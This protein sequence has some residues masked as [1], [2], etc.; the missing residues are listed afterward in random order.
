MKH[1]SL[2]I[3]SFSILFTLLVACGTARV[4]GVPGENSS[5]QHQIVILGTNDIHGALA[6]MDLKTR[7]E[8]GVKPVDYQAG[9][10]VYLASYIHKLKSEFGDRLLWL[11][12]GD[13]FQGTIE[14]NTA[15]G[16]PMVQ[17]FNSLGLD[18]AAIGNHEFDYGADSPNNPDLLSSLEDRMR[19]AKYPYLAA[20][21]DDKNTGALHAFP[22]T[23][24]SKIFLR[25]GVKIGVIGLSTLDTPTTTRAENVKSL[26]FVSL[27]DSTIREAKSLRDQGAQVIL[28]TAHVGI[29][30]QSGHAASGH[31][32]RKPTDD[33]GECEPGDEMTRLLNSLPA[34]TVDAVVSGHSHTVVH[35]WVNGIP[36]IQAGASGRYLNLIYLT[37]DEKSKTVLPALTRIEGPIPVCAKVFENQGDCNGDRPDPKKGRGPLVPA[38]FH[39]ETISADPA[40]VALLAPV[41]AKSQAIKAEVLGQALTPIEHFRTKESPLGNFVADAARAA[42]GADFAIVNAGGIRANWEQGP[43]TYGAVFRSLPFDNA[44]VKIDVT[45]RQLKMVLRVAESGSRGF[46]PVSGMT[47]K[48]IDPTV[49]APVN[50]L[51]GNHKI[52]PWEVNR[53]LEVK[54]PNGKLVSDDK[55]YTL[56]T[57]DFLAT[58]GDDYSW[59]MSQIP[60]DRFYFENALLI[61]D[62]VAS[63]LKKSGPLG[64]PA[65]PLVDANHPRIKF[66]KLEKKGKRRRS[67]HS[68]KRRAKLD[69]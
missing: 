57:I 48:L 50:D 42:T 36:V 25:N 6:P 3:W 64:D 2:S 8:S 65:H 41:F 26:E 29:A 51:N 22:N 49:E 4:E 33:Q 59:P 23:L 32:F 58:G 44:L 45:G 52:E 17:L 1:T 35:N 60:K 24:P 19:E 13:E 53:L 9:G 34:G 47:L 27:K 55:H 62:V 61:R 38:E 66:V 63:Y 10:A 30:C 18:A 46:P 14:S 15:K 11:D 28:I 31:M 39:G 16:A 56:A 37:Y 12:A 43:I 54:L 20:N 21:I 69:V 68:A 7:E 40:T 67:S 5:D